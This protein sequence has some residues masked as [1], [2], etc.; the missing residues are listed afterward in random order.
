LVPPDGVAFDTF[1]QN[2]RQA[3]AIHQHLG[4]CPRMHFCPIL[5]YFHK[6]NARNIN[7]M[8]VRIFLKNL[9]FNQNVY[10]RTSS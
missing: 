10:S 7:Y 4:A 5:R 8:T 6:N 2:A 1:Q 9:D 3:H